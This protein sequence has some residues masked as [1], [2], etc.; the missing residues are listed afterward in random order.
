[1]NQQYHNNCDSC[2]NTFWTENAFQTTCP[3]CQFNSAF[4]QLE[5]LNKL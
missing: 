2:E 3:D 1:M 5:N 4:N